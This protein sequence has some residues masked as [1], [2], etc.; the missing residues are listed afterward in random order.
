MTAP[1]AGEL[2][3]FERLFAYFERRRPWTFFQGQWESHYFQQITISALLD[4]ACNTQY[5]PPTDE[6]IG[7]QSGGMM[8]SDS[9]AQPLRLLNVENVVE[10]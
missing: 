9:R 7:S 8:K 6:V 1:W 4:F 10:A 5:R 3:L 2:E